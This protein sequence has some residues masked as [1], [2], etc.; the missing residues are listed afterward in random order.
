MEEE[1][2]EEGDSGEWRVLEFPHPWGPDLCGVAPGSRVGQRACLSTF[3]LGSRTPPVTR[4]QG[5][6]EEF[7]SRS[8]PT[9]MR[10]R[11]L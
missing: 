9:S 2:E 10:P 5:T 1:G 3:G 11:E 7:Q 4:S 8:T 6:P